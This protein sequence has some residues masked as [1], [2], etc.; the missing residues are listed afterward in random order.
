M[1]NDSSVRRILPQ[2][3]VHDPQAAQMSSF[4]FAPQQFPQRETQKSAPRPTI[5]PRVLRQ[6]TNPSS[7]I[8]SSSTST[9]VTSASR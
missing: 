5:H 1:S 9:T 6:L 4:Q 8:M 3:D 2:Q 7:Q